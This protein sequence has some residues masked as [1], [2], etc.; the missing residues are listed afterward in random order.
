MATATKTYKQQKKT[1]NNGD[2]VP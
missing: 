2:V 1:H